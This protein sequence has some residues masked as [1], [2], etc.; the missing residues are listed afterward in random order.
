MGH[1]VMPWHRERVQVGRRE[2]HEHLLTVKE[3]YETIKCDERMK[4]KITIFVFEGRNSQLQTEKERDRESGVGR[5]RMWKTNLSTLFYYF[6]FLLPSLFRIFFFVFRKV[7]HEEKPVLVAF[8]SMANGKNNARANIDNDKNRTW[9]KNVTVKKDTEHKPKKKM[10]FGTTKKE[11]N[12]HSKVSER[13]REKNVQRMMLKT[14]R[15]KG[16]KL[17]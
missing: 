9:T 12:T 17:C 10:C 13:E 14:I 15:E 7:A 1:K 16:A 11:Q 8:F 3:K 2:K 4:K 6:L 5:T